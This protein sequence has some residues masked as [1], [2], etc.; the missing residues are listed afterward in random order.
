MADARE[1]LS[2]SRMEEMADVC[3]TTLAPRPS[4]YASACLLVGSQPTREYFVTRLPE[5]GL[6]AFADYS[7]VDALIR[8]RDGRLDRWFNR[9]YLVSG[10]DANLFNASQWLLPIGRMTFDALCRQHKKFIY[11]V[12]NGSSV[13]FVIYAE[14]ND[15]IR[16]V[17]DRFKELMQL[18]EGLNIVNL[19]N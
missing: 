9:V 15:G 4:D 7:Q 14:D 2:E 17:I 13:E 16:V 19:G 10:A 5:G 11:T 1:T 3:R 18:D 12:K 8:E 6:R